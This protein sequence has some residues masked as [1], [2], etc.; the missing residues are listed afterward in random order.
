MVAPWVSRADGAEVKHLYAVE[1]VRMGGQ[2]VYCA[3]SVCGRVTSEAERTFG[4]NRPVCIAC[5]SRVGR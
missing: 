1:K 2:S 3:R 4:D 5:S